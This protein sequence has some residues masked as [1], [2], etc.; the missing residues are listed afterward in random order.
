MLSGPVV[1]I[2]R[3]NARVHRHTVFVVREQFKTYH[4]LND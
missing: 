4:L 3:H 1:Y 2:R